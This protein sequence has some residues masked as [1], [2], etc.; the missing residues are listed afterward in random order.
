MGGDEDEDEGEARGGGEEVARDK[1]RARV[2]VERGAR[3]RSEVRGT[4]WEGRGRR[5]ARCGARGELGEEAPEGQLRDL[6]DGGAAD[7]VEE[8]V[9]VLL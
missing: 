1:V 5:G 9:E 8:R 2:R 6:V 4:R 3:A 7:A